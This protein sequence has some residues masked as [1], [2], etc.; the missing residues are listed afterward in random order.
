M[1]DFTRKHYKAI[2]KVL[3][4]APV[5]SRLWNSDWSLIIGLLADLFDNDNPNFDR[6]KFME[7]CGRW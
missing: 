2:A 3:N 1:P 4:E 5:E 6:Y 7:A